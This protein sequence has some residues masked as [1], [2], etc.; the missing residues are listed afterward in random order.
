MVRTV[1]ILPAPVISRLT[2]GG[3]LPLQNRIR[4]AQP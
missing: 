2:P 1:N 4:A 3:A